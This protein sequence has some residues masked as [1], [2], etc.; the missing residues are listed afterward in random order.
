MP[1]VSLGYI[2]RCEATDIESTAA[3]VYRLYLNFE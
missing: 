3:T 1:G 2:I